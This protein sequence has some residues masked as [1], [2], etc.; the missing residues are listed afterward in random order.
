MADPFMASMGLKKVGI[1]S[2]RA[3]RQY[4]QTGLL[5]KSFNDSKL[6]PLEIL[7]PFSCW[8]TAGVWVWSQTSPL[9]P[10]RCWWTP[11]SPCW[12]EPTQD[13]WK[14]DTRPLSVGCFSLFLKP[15]Y[16]S[17]GEF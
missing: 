14:E 11:V 8:E 5:K 7:S 3:V 13:T 12:A 9:S 6:L 15:L 16:A 2:H 10:N 17:K 4:L 1:N